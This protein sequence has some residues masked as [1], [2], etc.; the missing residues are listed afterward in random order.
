MR[1]ARREIWL[2]SPSNGAR[3]RSRTAPALW[4]LVAGKPS[5]TSRGVARP[6]GCSASPMNRV[7]VPMDRRSASTLLVFAWPDIDVSWAM[8]CTSPVTERR[9]PFSAFARRYRRAARPLP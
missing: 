5:G 7:R 1:S 3:V 2:E 4:L 9:M 6:L 8:L